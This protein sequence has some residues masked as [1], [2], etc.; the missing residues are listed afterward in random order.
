MS[1]GPPPSPERWH[2]VEPLLDRA[3]EL[4]PDRR[5]AYLDS[6]CAGDT[7]LRA[8]VERLLRAV[9]ES[10]EFLSGRAAEFAE[11]ILASIPDEPPASPGTRVGPYRIIEE[12]GRGGMAVVYRAERDDGHFHKRVALKL[13]RPGLVQ[14]VDLL[15][16]FR[17]ERQI[18]ASLEH[19]GIARLLDGGVT[20]EGVPW[21]AMEYVDGTPID[22]SCHERRLTT[23]ARLDL[24]CA[25]CDAVHH[26]HRQGIVHR[27]LKPGN[28]LVTAEGLVK[29]LDFG[30]A[31]LMAGED[32]RDAAERTGPVT[33]LMTPEYAS[34]E[35]IR[36]G[37]V[38]AATDVYALGV[39]LHRLLTGYHPHDVTGG[40]GREEAAEPLLP[41]SLRTIVRRALREEPGQRYPD[42]GQMAAD[43]RRHLQ[44]RGAAVVGNRGARGI[45]SV[46]RTGRGLVSG[47][48]AVVVLAA[49]GYLA[50]PARGGPAMDPGRVVVAP[51]E[52]RT[53]QPDLEPVGSMAADWITQG[54]AHT[55]LVQVVPAT[56]ALLA[57]R[58]I[59]G[60]EDDVRVP[61]RVR[62]LA[63]ETRA[64]I[65]VS[66]AYYQLG[67]SLYLQATVTD[68]LARRVLQALDPVAAPADRPTAGLEQLRQRVMSALAIQLDPRMRDHASLS[69][70]PPP[71]EAYRAFAEGAELF[72]AQNFSAAVARLLEANALDSTFITPL[73]YA[74]IGFANLGNY[75]ASDSLLTLAR[76][77]MHQLT[78]FE[79]IGFGE[80]DAMLRGDHAASY[81]AAVRAPVVAPGT[82]AHWG[83]A[84]AA[85][86]LN[87]PREALRIY[88]DLD[89]QRGDMRGW[90]RYWRDLARAHHRVGDY[91]AELRVGRRTREL[92]PGEPGALR[93]EIRAL[94]ALGRT[95]Q[96]DAL[97]ERHLDGKPA[98]PALLR[99]AGLELL[100][101]G[102]TAAGEALLRRSLDRPLAGPSGDATARLFLAQGRSLM[103][104]LDD[105]ERL[106]RPLAN[107]LP[108]SV[109]VQ[110]ALGTLAARRD[111]AA[112][113]AAISNW[114]ASLERPYLHGRNTYWR[115]RI[116]AL[117]GD[118]DEAVQ[119]LRQAI[120]EGLDGLDLIH[121]EPDLAPLA[122]YAP[123][124]EFIRPKG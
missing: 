72:T 119:L 80:V 70:T 40:T 102:Y 88:S 120:E 75:A 114:L 14:E 47:T 108:G 77:R 81:L 103:G 68:V 118:R 24:F 7:L 112:E 93:A 59:A 43:V 115:A 25:V 83:L 82:F 23:E 116:A 96:L 26:A 92:F 94:A 76:P 100:A 35:Q 99:L 44:E 98:A 107:E 53:G 29:L 13:V 74:A 65:V 56:S 106:L 84:N 31:K 18:L 95:R 28:I 101:H 109:D 12:A 87:R 39:L 41:S 122:E 48:A 90:Y 57:A 66:G 51:L 21:L 37:P 67:D 32:G 1:F 38:T 124:R 5:P 64:A 79:R 97:L 54:L 69:A 36:G 2:Q 27:D 8:E 50:I 11:P 4:P 63:Q 33:R 30:I 123:F 34:P 49:V 9:D 16:R 78:E 3:L 104:E 117:L 105:A 45:P 46:L 91:R 17:E 121:L 113:A 22:R 55:G 86:R 58:F 6:A 89:P 60:S 19:S 61:D 110:G 52:N 42:A 71:F 62:R 15:R 85:L 20:P 111:H 73:L 10:D